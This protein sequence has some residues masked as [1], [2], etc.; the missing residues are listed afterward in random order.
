MIAASGAKMT[1]S[2]KSAPISAARARARVGLAD[3]AGAGQG[4]EAD[5]GTTQEPE[6]QCQLTLATNERGEWHRCRGNAQMVRRR[7]GAMMSASM[8]R[9]GTPYGPS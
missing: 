1:P 4:E 8:H 2:A 9:R 6:G 3:A 5:V 7:S